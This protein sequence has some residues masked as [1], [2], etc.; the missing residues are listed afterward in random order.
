[1]QCSE[2]LDLKYFWYFWGTF[3]YNCNLTIDGE[4]QEHN[5]IIKGSFHANAKGYW[6]QATGFEA[7]EKFFCSAVMHNTCLNIFRLQFDFSCT[8]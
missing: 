4:A 5:R 3:G 1:L 6:S 7:G 8:Q 2:G